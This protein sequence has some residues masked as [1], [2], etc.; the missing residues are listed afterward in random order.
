MLAVN[1]IRFLAVDA[2]EKAKSG[3]PGAPMGAA[4]L[5]YA[6]WDRFLKH[7]P[8]DP[9]WVDRDRFILSAGHAS[10]LL[11]A[12]L[13]LTG[14]QLSLEDIKNF[15][16]YGSKTPGHPEYG[17][18]PGVETTSGPLGQGFA[19]AV[20]LAIAETMLAAKFNRP[21]FTLFDHQTWVLASDGDLQEGI[22]SEAASLAGTLKLGK[23]ICLYD[24]N[25][26]QL[27]G[28]T[29][30]FTENVAQRFRAYDW[31]VIGPIDGM[32]IETVSAAITR[33]RAQ[34]RQPSLI[35]CKT[36]IGYGSPGKAGRSSAHGEPLGETE[37]ALAK[38]NLNWNYPPFTVP[39][40]V[41]AHM[42]QAIE[43]G[44]TLQQR[45]QA[46]QESYRSAYPAEAAEMESFIK[47]G[48]PFDWDKVMA[49]IVPATTKPAAT[50]DTAGQALNRL[51]AVLPGLVGGAAD[52]AS[53]TRAVIKNA[54]DY[55]A[56][57]RLGR[58]LR[59][60][61]REHAMGGIVNGLALHG[62]RPFASTFLVF[63]DYMKPAIRL[64]ALMKLPVVY[65]FSH[66]SIG[67][68]EDGPTHQPVEQLA[69]LRSIPNLQV[70][71]PCDA[72]ETV[73]AWKAAVL[74]KDGPT[75]LILSRQSLPLLDRQQTGAAAGLQKGGYI[76][77]EN[78]TAPQVII[79]SSGS[80]VNLAL[81]AG[82]SLQQRGLAVR[83]VSLPCWELFEKQSAEYRTAV[84][85]SGTALIISVEAAATFGWQRYT[86][87]DGLNLGVD[88]F[89]LS[90]PGPQVYRELEITSE[91]IEKMVW[92]YLKNKP[93]ES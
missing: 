42:R 19:N 32:D 91:K 23:L 40:E 44:R 63:S 22:S 37:T 38:K 27:D 41:A 50:R 66:D 80:E 30:Y 34:T 51:A 39:E 35:I 36:I 17:M 87:R 15:R 6:L 7:N 89:G 54:P 21:G 85:P 88:R 52:L 24:S 75:A 67:V 53:S 46:L 90:A 14:Y 78:G 13:H 48:P 68:G 65:L 28:P 60:G 92:D 58:N 83:V 64:A 1:T 26:V 2:V 86:G 82:H 76:L 18:T 12:L 11:Y 70:I 3:H 25:D 61:V 77:W 59:F 9:Q 57:N 16:Q 8:L 55:N 74:K 10:M 56:A 20:G 84:L 62:F 73:E 81:T 33:A 31:N 93:L 45:W 69:G 29:D 71:R 79:I 4:P 43:R 72:A 47:A 5:A 49:D